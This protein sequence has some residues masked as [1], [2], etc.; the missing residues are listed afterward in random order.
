MPLSISDKGAHP[1]CSV[2]GQ[3]IHSSR[4]AEELTFLT[5]YKMETM[6]ILPSQEFVE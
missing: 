4:M 3:G 2:Y 5:A 6:L 1:S